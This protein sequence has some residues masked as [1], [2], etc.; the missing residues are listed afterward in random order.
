VAQLYP[1]ALDSLFVASYDSQGYCG[2]ILTRLHT[3]SIVIAA[4][5][6]YIVSVRIEQRT[7]FPTAPLFLCHA[8]ISL[9]VQ[10][11]TLLVVLLLLCA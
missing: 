6:N 5:S 1:R 10:R 9:T 11:I 4:A 3:G 7:Y 2:G 8:G